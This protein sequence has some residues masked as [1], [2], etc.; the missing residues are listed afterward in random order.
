[1]YIAPV[2]MNQL[3]GIDGL[4]AL[5][6][7]SVISIGNYDGVH[8]GHAAIIARMHQLSKSEAR[9]IVTFEPHPLT[10]L[11]PELAPPRLTTNYRKQQL[12]ESM[13][14]TH[15]VT[16]PPTP[17]ILGLTAEKFWEMLRDQVRPSHIVE[18]SNFNFG[19][20]REG[21]I[22][23]MM[24][25]AASTPIRVHR[26]PSQT[27]VL[28]DRSVVDVSSSIIRW[29]LGYG[30]VE[31]ATRCLGRPFELEGTV[32]QGYQRGRLL[33]FP[34]AN[35]ECADH[36]IPAD[37]VYAGRCEVNG[38][39]YAAAISIGTTPTFSQA[40]YQIE[41]HLIGYT[42]DLYG[43]ALRVALTRWVR[44]QMKFPNVDVLRRQLAK[45]IHQIA[46]HESV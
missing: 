27:C 22:E 24:Q 19:K 14:I 26:E 41:V 39:S 5:P 35:L 15:L 23:R 12:L 43:R 44:D 32:I 25:W 38:R 16:L 33:G 29:L 11:R 10:V 31:D 18:G 17:E 1:M 2:H 9:V 4:C 37:G 13:G 30:R 7:G 28:S 20:G 8:V 34:T 45:D 42:G 36:I 40:R 46:R 6:P 3:S 21:S